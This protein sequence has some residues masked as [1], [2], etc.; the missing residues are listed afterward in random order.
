MLKFAAPADYVGISED[1]TF[2]SSTN[3][4]C[5]N[6]SIEND[7]ILE[8][9]ESFT[10]SLTTSNSAVRLDQDVARVDILED[11]SDGK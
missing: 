6:V 4:I 1:L 3:R 5:V 8:A 2:D 9:T 11:L 10:A 7:D